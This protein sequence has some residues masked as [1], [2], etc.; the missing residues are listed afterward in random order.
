[1]ELNSYQTQ[2]LINY[3]NKLIEESNRA[4]DYASIEYD[5]TKEKVLLSEH[6]VKEKIAK[7]IESIIYGE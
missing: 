1:M 7:E 4:Y 6:F 2:K 3:K 5:K